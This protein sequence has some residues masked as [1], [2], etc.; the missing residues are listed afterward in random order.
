MANTLRPYVECVRSTLRAALCLQAFP[1]Q[2]VERQSKPE[3]EAQAHPELLRRPLLICRNSAEKVLVES[4]VNSVR[5]SIK[6]KQV[7][8]ADE[9]IASTF[10]RFLMQRADSI[11]IMRKKP[12]DG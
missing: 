7:D 5:V 1:C 12:L 8:Q 10:L 6:V 2:Q 4:S 3:V 11:G 9:Y